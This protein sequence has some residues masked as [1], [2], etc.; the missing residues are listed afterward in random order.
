MMKMNK[1]VSILSIGAVAVAFAACHNSE[2]TFPDFDGGTTAYFAYQYPIRTLILGNVETYDNTS[3]NEGRFTIYGTFGGSYDGVDAKIPVKVDESLTDNLY[4]E[5]GTKVKAM[6][7]DYY[8]LSGEELDYGGGF[9]GGVEVK[10]NEKFFN[11][12]LAVKNTYVIPVVMGDNFSGVDQINRGKPMI[13]G[14]S[15]MRQDETKWDNLPKDFVM[16]CVN[17]I[18]EYTATYLR[19]GVDNFDKLKY[20]DVTETVTGDDMCIVVHAEAKKEQV[21]DNQFW[22]DAVDPFEEK[23]TITITMDVKATKEAKATSQVHEAPG[24]YKGGGFGDVNFTTEWNTITLKGTIAS[25]QAGGHSIALNL[26]EFADANDYYFDNI[27]VKV[28]DIEKIA[29]IRCDNV[30]NSNFYSKT[31]SAGAPGANTYESTGKTQTITTTYQVPDGYGKVTENRHCGEFVENG[32]VVYTTSES[33]NQILLPIATTEVAGVPTSCEL[34]LTFDG[35]NC[36]IVS[37]N[38]AICKASGSGQ[39]VKNG[40]PKAWGNKDRDVLY[41]DYTIDFV[42]DDVHY[43]TKDTLVWRDRGAA[44]GI[45][46]FK[47]VYKED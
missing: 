30:P 45:Q 20:K 38:E 34:L 8:E 31:Y 18:N 10:L 23:Q 32:E 12:P 37:N 41:L 42:Q 27:S 29:N 7:Q 9:R 21:W 35:D 24:S 3:D 39:Y 16:F 22:I 14:S 5:D 1:V 13:D 2:Q 4:F 19:R 26:S 15:P 46:T 25:G 44:A 40:A 33:R 6:P 11:D 28:N 17:Y 36:T 47:P 43:A